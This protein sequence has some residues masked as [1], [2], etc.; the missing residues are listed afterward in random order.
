[1]NSAVIVKEKKRYQT[2]NIKVA[3]LSQLAVYIKVKSLP[4]IIH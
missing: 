2:R 1:M 3:H 4:P